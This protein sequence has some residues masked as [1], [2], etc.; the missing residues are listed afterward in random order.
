MDAALNYDRHPMLHKNLREFCI[1]LFKIAADSLEHYQTLKQKRGL[2]DFVDQEQLVLSA[3]DNRNV[4]DV[5]R[6]EL[7][8][9]LVDEFQDTSP[10]QL[11]LFLKLAELA[12]E[13]VF[14]GD[15]KQAI[16]GFRG[17]DPELMKAV[18]RRS[19]ETGRGHGYS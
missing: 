11:A 13:A 10:I 19:A 3:L 6:D 12:K 15:V 9:L 14:V 2:I 4:T 16:Y 17:S 1:N 5:L 18:F 8:L 7:D